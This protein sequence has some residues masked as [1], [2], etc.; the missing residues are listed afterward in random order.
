MMDSTSCIGI[1]LA[2]GLSSRMG[3]DKALLQRNGQTQLQHGIELLTA[4]G[5]EQVIVSRNAEGFVQ[6]HY[7]AAGP[8]AGIHAAIKSAAGAHSYL[9]MPVDMPLLPVEA[10]Q[11]LMQQPQNT[12][13]E[14]GPFPCLIHNQPQLLQQ[15]ENNIES[16][17]LR[18]RYFLKQ[19]NTQSLP[20]SNPDWLINTNTPAEW[21]DVTAS[22]S[23]HLLR[24]KEVSNGTPRQ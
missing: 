15:I 12:T 5:C 14:K 3:S 18:I 20:V 24:N 6:D 13:L 21:Q 11:Q 10:L 22:K 1:L 16:G 9:I 23:Q 8:L 4:A 7:Q 2:G 19:L 17:E